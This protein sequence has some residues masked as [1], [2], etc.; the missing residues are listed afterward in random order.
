VSRR[1]RTLD[2]LN[3][4]GVVV[5]CE[6]AS[7]AIPRDL[8]R[9]GLSRHALTS[10][11]AWDPHARELAAMLASRLACPLFVGQFSRL[12]IDLNRSATNR[13]L[14]PRTAFGTPVPG[15]RALPAADRKRRIRRYYEPY[16]M[17]VEGAVGESVQ[18]VGHCVHISVH[19]FAPHLH[20]T[21]RRADIGLLYDPS[22]KRE[23]TLALDLRR[24]LVPLGFRVRMNYPY[25]GTADGFTTWLRRQLP[26]R[27]YVGLEIEVNQ[28]ILNDRWMQRRIAVATA[29]VLREPS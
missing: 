12:V 6:H 13:S 16:R 21:I 29:E 9:L 11:I 7:N 18:A 10:H 24:A 5:S 15:N 28:R 27:Q 4:T 3:A 22:R 8:N 23:R 25:K 1:E 20:G 2:R 19:T 14:I 17:R 26:A